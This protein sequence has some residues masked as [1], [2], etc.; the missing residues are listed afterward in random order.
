MTCAEITIIHDAETFK[1]IINSDKY[2]LFMFSAPWCGPCKKVFPLFEE[3]SLS[4][5]TVGFYK[6]DIEDCDTEIEKNVSVKVLPTFILYKS[7]SVVRQVEGA[8]MDNINTLLES[9]TQQ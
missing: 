1:E 9:I 5:S 3:L 4:Y 7:G 2:N 6:V 8:D